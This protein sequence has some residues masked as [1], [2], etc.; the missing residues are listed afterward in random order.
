M[1]STVDA[2]LVD[3]PTRSTPIL[4]RRRRFEGMVALS[5]VFAMAP[6]AGVYGTGKLRPVSHSVI[7][8]PSPAVFDDATAE[9]FL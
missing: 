4:T 2:L 7:R 5:A 8:V 3:R 1:A 6:L 9:R